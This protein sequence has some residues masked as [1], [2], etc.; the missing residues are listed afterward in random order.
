MKNK[1]LPNRIWNYRII[2]ISGFFTNAAHQFANTKVIFPW[3]LSSLGISHFVSAILGPLGQVG[4]FISSFFFT[5]RVNSYPLKKHIYFI[6]SFIRAFL[7]CML[8]FVLMFSSDKIIISTI[9]LIL[10][11]LMGFI[12]N[13]SK[14]ASRTVSNKTIPNEQRGRLLSSKEIFGSILAL[15]LLIAHAIYMG[16]GSKDGHVGR[17]F[18][19]STLLLISGTVFIT[20]KEAFT[21]SDAPKHTKKNSLSFS[22]WKK[23]PLISRQY[24]LMVLFSQP[25]VLLIAFLTL[26][27]N[28]RIAHL[29]ALS[30]FAM[31]TA[32]GNGIAGFLAKRIVDRKTLSTILFGTLLSAV[33]TVFIIF[34]GELQESVQLGLYC[35]AFLLVSA[36]LQCVS[37]GQNSFLVKNFQQT[38]IPKIIGYCTTLSGFTSLLLAGL[39]GFIAH[40]FTPY[41]SIGILGILQIVYLPYIMLVF[42]HKSM[43]S[44]SSP[45]NLI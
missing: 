29:H 22:E 31:S 35:L 23:L 13:L 30:V 15:V 34:L 4:Q 11:L 42:R 41:I 19:A 5:N 1:Q 9:I 40:V 10:I 36:S 12:S 3:I 28:S 8:A 32:I 43:T 6:C 44:K 17:L 24:V 20:I 18:I 33:T 38:E 7:I 2:L 45:D 21:K 25:N 26:C 16:A 37:L 27:A 14:M 39:L